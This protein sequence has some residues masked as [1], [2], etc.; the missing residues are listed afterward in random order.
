MVFSIC[1]SVAE[2][3]GQGLEL[4]GDQ[5]QSFGRQYA[6][7]HVVQQPHGQLADALI[8]ISQAPKQFAVFCSHRAC[9][10]EARWDANGRVWRPTV[11]GTADRPGRGESTGRPAG[12][13]RARLPGEVSSRRRRGRGETTTPTAMPLYA[14]ASKRK[15][16][17]TQSISGPFRPTW[18]ASGGRCTACVVAVPGRPRQWW[19]DSMSRLAGI[20]WPA[21]GRTGIG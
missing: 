16:T 1:G 9:L 2:L 12:F 21:T 15:T 5:A 14:L 20:C 4:R 3:R 13:G 18:M 8:E 10:G 17:V 7:L 19:L 11:A 6:A